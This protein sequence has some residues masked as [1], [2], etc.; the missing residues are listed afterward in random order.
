MTSSPVPLASWSTAAAGVDE[1]WPEEWCFGWESDWM[2]DW[3]ED[4][5]WPIPEE[6]TCEWHDGEGSYLVCG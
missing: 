6:C 3:P 1:D 2:E 4:W 5:S